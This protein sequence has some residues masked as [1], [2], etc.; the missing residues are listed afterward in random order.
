MKI[1]LRSYATELSF[2]IE[3]LK[4]FISKEFHRPLSALK[5]QLENGRD[6]L[7]PAF[8]WK[9]DKPVV[10]KEAERYDGPDKSPHKVKVG[11]QFE[12]NFVSNEQSRKTGLWTVTKMVTHIRVYSAN[13]DEEILH[14]HHDLKNREQLGPH[15][16][17]QFSEHYLKD[18][19]RIPIAVPRFP[20]TAILPTDCFD[21]VLVTLPPSFIQ[22]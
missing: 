4:P 13:N 10:T 12:S 8:E 1:N 17:M 2:W 14:F 16:H 3:A 9:L 22:F 15:V 19:G 20:V 5:E 18:K 7:R 6:N 11:W 21:L